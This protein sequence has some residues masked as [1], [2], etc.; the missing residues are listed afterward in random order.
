MEGYH[1]IR[2]S[3]DVDLIIKNCLAFHDS[4][5]KEA[6]FLS[7]AFVNE[8]RA[9]ITETL[10]RLRILIQSQVEGASVEMVFAGL[11]ETTLRE[12]PP[13]EVGEIVESLLEVT[14]DPKDNKRILITF[15]LGDTFRVVARRAFWR[16]RGDWLGP[17]PRLG[18]EIPAPWITKAFPLTDKLRR[19]ENC[20]EVWESNRI[21]STCPRCRQLT[22][23]QI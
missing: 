10:E 9:L 14:V 2:D 16:A 1:E 5:L 20:Q 8:E 7:E 4:I 23:L 17:E 18:S 19:C 12:P 22:E 21:L 3:K 13:H 6:H 11:L 15:A